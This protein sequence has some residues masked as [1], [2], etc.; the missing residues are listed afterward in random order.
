MLA[1]KLAAIVAAQR[2]PLLALFC[3]LRT[4]PGPSAAREKREPEPLAASL[5]ARPEGR[6]PAHGPAQPERVAAPTS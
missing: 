6:V 5:A 2:A 4:T 1:L 3:L